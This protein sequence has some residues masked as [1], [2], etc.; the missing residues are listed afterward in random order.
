MARKG[1]TKY[2]PRKDGLKALGQS[3]AMSKAM[4]QEARDI[5]GV[6]QSAG[7]SEYGARPTV[8]TAGWDNERRAGATAYESKMHWDDWNNSV[9]KR[10]AAAMV[11]RG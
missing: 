1:L 11:R 7:S 10:T 4:M 8:V 5:A 2:K 6:A 9:L 3:S